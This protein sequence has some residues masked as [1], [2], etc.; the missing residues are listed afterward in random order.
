M[1]IKMVNACV[2]PFNHFWLFY[3][4]TTNQEFEVLV[5]DTLHNQTERYFNPLSGPA[6]PV[7][8]P[9]AFATWP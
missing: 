6:P 9:D 4:A 2:A 1:L 3:A 5:N 8:D 7:Q